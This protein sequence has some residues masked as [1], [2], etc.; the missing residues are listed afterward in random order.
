MP[1]LRPFEGAEPLILRL[2]LTTLFTLAVVAAAW[3]IGSRGGEEA[4]AAE[5]MSGMQLL[6]SFR[7]HR[8]ETKHVI[9]RG[10]EDDFSPTGDEPTAIHPRLRSP[11]RE[12]VPDGGSY[13]QS[14]PDRHFIDYFEL[15]TNVARGL[16][17][18]GL[19][20]TAANENDS[21]SIGDLAHENGP[22]PEN[23]SLQTRVNRLSLEQGWE[24]RGSLHFSEFERIRFKRPSA[25][26][27]VQRGDVHS[28]GPYRNLLDYLRGG[29][30]LRVVDVR[31]QDDTS[32][33]FMA[34]AVCLEPPGGTGVT[35]ATAQRSRQLTG[36]LTSLSCTG[37]IER[38]R[39]CN[40]YVGDT[41][42]RSLLPIA[43]FQPRNAPVPQAV[44][45]ADFGHHWS[46]GALA[47]TPP[48]A[49]S[50]F[51]SIADVD[52]YCARH[53]GD[54]WRAATYH[55]GG[56]PGELTAFGD[57]LDPS[58]RVWIDIRGQPYATC[59]AH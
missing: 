43:C 9:V 35:L 41:P 49:A 29:D 2:V 17:V 3:L 53:F 37:V 39:I 33:D 7:C 12:S 24:V 15:P 23:W 20:P 52:S 26:M 14:Q 58:L 1:L 8:S 31:I 44:V 42:C 46:G 11:R 40:P 27:G 56:Q 4:K 21:F 38:E 59:W 36:D 30:G 18:I 25:P 51:A 47:I 6:Q 48:R 55:D 19:R 32:V 10:A 28:S 13:D 16:F 57:A 45:E 22:E 54:G 50:D 34:V 5:A